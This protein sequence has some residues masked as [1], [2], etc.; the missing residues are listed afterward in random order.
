MRWIDRV[1]NAR[2]VPHMYAFS[3]RFLISFFERPPQAKDVPMMTRATDDRMGGQRPCLLL[4]SSVVIVVGGVDSR[5]N[6]HQREK[7]AL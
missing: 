3:L 4:A 7:T 5:A 6:Y 2:K 1:A